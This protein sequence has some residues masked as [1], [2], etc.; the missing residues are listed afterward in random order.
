MSRHA[1]KSLQRCAG[2]PEGDDWLE[3]IFYRSNM[4]IR[5]I[6]IYTHG[7]ITFADDDILFLRAMCV[8]IAPDY[9]GAI[10]AKAREPSSHCVR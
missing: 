10:N 2:C 6:E 7:L 3:E 1:K 8:P 5:A 9:R 4:G